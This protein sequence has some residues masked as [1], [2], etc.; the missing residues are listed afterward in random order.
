MGK[1]RGEEMQEEE[2]EGRGENSTR[3]KKWRRSGEEKGREGR[4]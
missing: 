3:E 2:R 4:E 1:G